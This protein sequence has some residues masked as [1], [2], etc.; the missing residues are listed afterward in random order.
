MKTGRNDLA[1]KTGL[2]ISP[3]IGTLDG[4]ILIA[5]RPGPGVLISPRPPARYGEIGEIDVWEGICLTA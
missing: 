1:V 4:A 3:P 5:R 2:Y